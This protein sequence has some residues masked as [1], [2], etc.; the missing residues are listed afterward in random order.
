MDLSLLAPMSKNQE[1]SVCVDRISQLPDA[2]LSRILSFMPTKYAAQTSVLSTRWKYLWVSV[3]V[4]DFEMHL[5]VNYKGDRSNFDMY[6]KRIMSNFTS[7]VDRLLDLRGNTTTK[8]FRLSCFEECD[9]SRLFAWLNAMMLSNVQEVDLEL[10]M[11]DLG[12]LPRSLFTSKTLVVLRLCGA[13]LLNVPLD[14]S[15]PSLKSLYLESINY[16]GDASIKRLLSSCHVLEE[17]IIPRFG[18]DNVWTFDVSVPS[19]KRLTLDFTGCDE[20]LYGEEELADGFEGEEFDGESDEEESLCESNEE[21]CVGESDEEEFVSE[22]DEEEF[23]GE[24]DEEESVDELDQEESVDEIEEEASKTDEEELVDEIEEEF[25]RCV[26]EHK[27][28]VNASNLEY[29]KLRDHMSH[30][31]LVNELPSLV[32]ADVD[33]CKLYRNRE[34][35]VEGDYGNSAY[36]LLRSIANA[37]RLSLSGLTLR[38]LI[39]ASES[40][41]PTFS[42]L[43]SLELGF[44]KLNGVPLLPDLLK[45]SP[46]LEILALPE[47]I[48]SPLEQENY[49]DEDMFFEYHWMP[50]TDVPECVLL[51]LK[52]VEIHYFCGKQEEELKLV[53]ISLLYKGIVR[54]CI[55]IEAID[56]IA[57]DEHGKLEWCSDNH[58]NI[59]EAAAPAKHVFATLEGGAGSCSDEGTHT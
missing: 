34:W 43:I 3:A 6:E 7:S 54:S 28:V 40:N 41:L 20:A 47:G 10:I 46:K 56:T 39:N 52:K 38:S 23:V 49:I 16:R 58:S 55:C 44:D 8:K 57:A 51:S 4:L 35:E 5:Y 1:I 31:I 33:I 48:T 45:C 24:S 26:H 18:E 36:G 21:E 22:S 9:P 29:L 19:L 42:N 14:V 37:K 17:L 13:F 25:D 53:K 59:G 50:P 11:H 15:L 2:V 12:K 27:V 32:E 30:N